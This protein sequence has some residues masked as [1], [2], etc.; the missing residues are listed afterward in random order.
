MLAYPYDLEIKFRHRIYEN[1]P[2]NRQQILFGVFFTK[3][4]NGKLLLFIICEIQV[5]RDG[6]YSIIPLHKDGSI[7]SFAISEV[8]LKIFLFLRFKYMALHFQ[9][10]IQSITLNPF[11]KI[12][13]GYQ[14]SLNKIG[15]S[16]GNFINFQKLTSNFLLYFVQ[17]DTHIF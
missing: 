11:H 4:V 7:V 14:F 17:E 12:E 10:L 6:S 5:S 13:T 2:L 16:K 9:C 8:F 3:S 15:I 1:M